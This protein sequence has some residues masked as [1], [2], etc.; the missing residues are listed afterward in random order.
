V[1]WH[2]PWEGPTSPGRDIAR[3]V[4]GVEWN[5]DCAYR[6]ASR[7]TIEW[8]EPG[9]WRP[10]LP[11]ERLPLGELVPLLN[12]V[13]DWVEASRPPAGRHWMWETARRYLHQRKHPNVYGEPTHG[14]RL[15]LGRAPGGCFVCGDESDLE[16]FCYGRMTPLFHWSLP[17]CKRHGSGPDKAEHPKDPP[18]VEM[19]T[20][21]VRR[22][23]DRHER[24]EV[25]R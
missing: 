24:I 17:V 11:A 9:D 6:T 7:Q 3:A 16:G 2:H 14:Y 23:L 13:E 4:L 20:P 25:V 10:L 15:N 8:R 18:P 19:M 12:E 22:W 21:D 1:A 5:D